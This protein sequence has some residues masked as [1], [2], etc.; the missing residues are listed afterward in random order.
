MIRKCTSFLWLDPA[1]KSVSTVQIWQTWEPQHDADL[2]VERKRKG[3]ARTVPGIKVGQGNHKSRSNVA[4]KPFPCWLLHQETPMHQFCK[5][6]GPDGTQFWVG[7]QRSQ[8]TNCREAS[9]YNEHPRTLPSHA[10]A[11][12]QDQAGISTNRQRARG[13]VEGDGSRLPL[14]QRERRSLPVRRAPRRRPPLPLAPA[15]RPSVAPVRS[16]VMDQ[17]GDDGRGRGRRTRLAG[18]LG[19]YA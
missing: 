14:A 3:A 4:Q 7:Q 11:R 1:C 12:S 8:R 19:A 13:K 9:S 16:A 17:A 15:R 10:A 6:L 5:R 2:E 18:R